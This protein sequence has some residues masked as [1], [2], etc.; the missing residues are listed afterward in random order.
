M[1]GVIDGGIYTRQQPTGG[2]IHDDD[3]L[4]SEIESH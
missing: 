4:N 3:V 2:Y 1:E